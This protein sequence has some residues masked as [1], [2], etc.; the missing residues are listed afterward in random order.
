MGDLKTKWGD[1]SGSSTTS[2][3]SGSVIYKYSPPISPGRSYIEAVKS[4]SEQASLNNSDVGGSSEQKQSTVNKLDSSESQQ[5]LL[6]NPDVD[7]SSEQKQS[8]VNKLDSS[9]SQQALLNNPDVDGSSEQKQLTI[10]KAV[11]S[12]ILSSN[13]NI[14][15]LNER[16][17]N[18]LQLIEDNNNKLA[19]I[20]SQFYT[21]QMAEGKCIRCDKIPMCIGY[22]A[23]I[24]DINKLYDIK[25]TL[26]TKRN[27]YWYKSDFCSS[28]CAFEHKH[29]S[30][31]FVC[32]FCS[33]EPISLSTCQ[34]RFCDA[35]D[36]VW[37][38]SCQQSIVK[39]QNY[40]F[41]KICN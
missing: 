35:T 38:I 34:N 2:S 29:E 25:L 18:K 15:I 8:T 31:Q 7:G 26:D 16:K 36:Y 4:N 27:I 11:P 19:E 23:D 30:N 6:N 33:R 9:E 20:N 37:Y 32:T 14:N 13:N 17:F 10:N 28:Q 5:A 24:I 21:E 41:D 12:D 3:P 1:Q 22:N 39:L 40:E